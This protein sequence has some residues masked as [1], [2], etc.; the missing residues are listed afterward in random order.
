M[1]LHVSI[2]V[3]VYNTAKYLK[4]CLDS[5]AAQ[6]LKDIEIICIDDGSTDGSEKILDQYAKKDPRFK[7]L[8]KQNTGYGDSMNQ[9]LKLAKGEYVGIVEPDDFVEQ[10]MF[11]ELYAFAEKAK[12]DIVRSNYYHH[13]QQ[14]GKTIDEKQHSIPDKLSR[15]IVNPKQYLQ[16]FHIPPAIWSAIYRREFIEKNKI[17]FLPTPGASFQDT[18]FFFKTWASAKKIALD[19]RAFLH[20]RTDNAASSVKS[21][22]KANNIVKEYHS[23]EK[24]LRERKLQDFLPTMEATKFA[25]YHWNLKRLAGKVAYNF[26]ILMQKEF[27]DSNKHG[28][29]KKQDFP[30]K[31]WIALQVLL[32]LPISVFLRL[33]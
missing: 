4:Q 27:R 3:P 10:D 32:K 12:V 14:K 11:E 31:H 19:S 28:L 2:I 24:F 16:L 29:L 7:V 1:M 5:L 20:Y 18:G 30:I 6:T 13:S 17:I 8:H 26:G 21:R 25:A 9:G 15:M 23:I 33:P 22:E